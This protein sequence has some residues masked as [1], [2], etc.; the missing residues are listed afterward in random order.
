MEIDLKIENLKFDDF[1]RNISLQKYEQ[2]KQ[3]FIRYFQSH[4]AISSIYEIGGINNPGISDIDLILVFKEDGNLTNDDYNFLNK[5]DNY[6]F[7]HPPFV[8]HKDLFPYL[9]YLFYAS[10][11]RKLV[12]EDHTFLKPTSNKELKQLLWIISTEAALSRLRDIVY[13]ITWRN[14]ISIRKMLLKLNSIRH[15]VN[16]YLNLIKKADE[17][18]ISRYWE[19][20]IE[21]ITALRKSWFLYHKD[22]QIKKTRYNLYAGI[23]VLLEIINHLALLSS[24]IFNF[25]LENQIGSLYIFP[26]SLQIF[27]FES[28]LKTSI[29]IIPNPFSL[30]SKIS[31]IYKRKIA[32]HVNDLSIITL[33]QELLHLFVPSNYGKSDTAKL[34]KENLIKRCNDKT[35][36]LSRASG[37][38][39]IL[40]RFQLV[41]KYNSFIKRKNFYKMS[42]LLMASWLINRKA[43]FYNVKNAIL[44]SMLK[45]RIV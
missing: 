41:D 33:S 28:G 3:E 27:K 44:K 14:N 22:E 36:Q 10:N 5:L 39:L 25:S 38:G 45:F 2:S 34:M 26:N 29:K 9:D 21:Q 37:S 20:F 32:R 6:I 42:F 12:G 43:K 11:I 7:V 18:G 23:N 4:R 8:I 30:L 17:K 1:P 35:L 24:R 16:L 15:N 31:K 40:K 13:Q 19:G